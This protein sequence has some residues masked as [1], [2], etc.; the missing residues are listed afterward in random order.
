[1]EKIYGI[2]KVNEFRQLFAKLGAL[3]QPQQLWGENTEFTQDDVTVLYSLHDVNEFVGRTLS[4]IPTMKKLATIKFTRNQTLLERLADI[5]VNALKALGI[6]TKDSLLEE[7]MRTN[8]AYLRE[9]TGETNY[10]PLPFNFNNAASI[11]EI[12]SGQKTSTTRKVNETGLQVGESAIQT[13][14]TEQVRVIYHG[15]LTADEA[16]KVL[17]KSLSAE[18]NQVIKSDMQDYLNGVGTRHVFGLQLINPVSLVNSFKRDIV[19]IDNEVELLSKL[20]VTNDMPKGYAFVHDGDLDKTMSKLLNFKEERK[21]NRYYLEAVN[22]LIDVTERLIKLRNTP[23]STFTSNSGKPP[24]FNNHPV[25][26]VDD[27]TNDQQVSVVL[28]NG[29]LSINEGILRKNFREQS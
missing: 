14:G 22:R 3:P 6:V 19:Q 18:R 12:V 4:H 10:T 8:L 5:V 28:K 29:T 15:E 16:G 25:V 21:S 1:L 11:D 27:L 20:S 7:V 2:G 13:I 9:I 24:M 17:G 23:S 26:F